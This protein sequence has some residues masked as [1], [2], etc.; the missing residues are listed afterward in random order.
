[1]GHSGLFQKGGVVVDDA[2]LFP[3]GDL[4]WRGEGEGI[5]LVGL[6]S[7]GVVVRGV[8]L[9][10]KEG[11]NSRVGGAG[12][13]LDAGVVAGGEGEALRAIPR[14]RCGEGG[15]ILVGKEGPN[16]RV[17]GAGLFL[18]AGVVAGGEGEA[19]RTIPRWRCGEGGNPS[20]KG[21]S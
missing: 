15:V 13:F 2:G 9:V 12:L 20:W 8:I 3:D 19:L 18:D 6:F 21:G 10:G 16:S 7:D 17:G 11:P 4:V 5:V 14:W 1:M